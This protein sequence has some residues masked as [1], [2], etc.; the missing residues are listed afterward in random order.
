MTGLVLVAPV[1]GDVVPMVNVPD[2]VFSAG[3]VGPGAAIEPFQGGLTVVAPCD[4]T[5]VKSKPHGI[6]IKTDAGVGVLVHLGIDTIRLDGAGFTTLVR[7]GQYVTAGQPIV[8][9]NTSVAVEA[10]YA[11]CS[12]LIVMG[13]KPEAVSVIAQAPKV[14]GGKPFLSVATVDSSQEPALGGV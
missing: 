2:P 8:L 5:I 6:V 13:V 7:E 10:G 11:L 14:E 9:W 4:G 1:S 3:L 12:P